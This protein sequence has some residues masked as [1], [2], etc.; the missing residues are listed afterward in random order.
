MKKG[1]EHLIATPALKQWAKL[2]SEHSGHLLLFRVGDFYECFF[3]DAEE[4]SSLLNIALTRRTVAQGSIPMAGVPHHASSQYISKLKSLGK[5]VAL[6][7]QL[8]SPE[9]ARAA[10]RRV[11]KRAVTRIITPGTCVDDEYLA[12]DESAL[13]VAVAQKKQKKTLEV[14]WSDV[15]AGNG[16]WK[17]L[18]SVEEVLSLLSA[19]SPH[20]ILVVGEGA[21]KSWA[22]PLCS[23]QLCRTVEISSSSDDDGAREAIERYLRASLMSNN[24]HRERGQK[25]WSS[26]EEDDGKSTMALLHADGGT[27]SALEL[28]HSSGTTPQ[29]MPWATSTSASASSGIGSLLNVFTSCGHRYSAAALRLL[30]QRINNPLHPSEHEEILSRLKAVHYLMTEPTLLRVLHRI[31]T[32]SPMYGDAE[33]ALQRI[34][35]A[36]QRTPL[37]LAR[38]LRS[39][40]LALQMCALL[41]KE[42]S[43]YDASPQRWRSVNV[44]DQLQRVCESTLAMVGLDDLNVTDVLGIVPGADALLDSL[45]DPKSFE[46]ELQALQNK[47]SET[48]GGIPVK[49]SH[50]RTPEEVYFSVTDKHSQ[51]VS[52]HARTNMSFKYVGQ[53]ASTTRWTT[54][55]LERFGK[56]F[57]TAERDAMKRSRMLL[58]GCR[59]SL[60]QHVVEAKEALR[61]LYDL[62]L[63]CGVATTALNVGL[64]IPRVIVD[65]SGAT[66]KLQSF[67][68]PVVRHL[69]G[70]VTSNDL[71]LASGTSRVA[72]V[73]GANMGGKST[74]LRSVALASWC[75]QAGLPSA[76]SNDSVLSLFDA[77]FVRCGSADDVARDRS[78]FLTEM[79]GLS[80]LLSVSSSVSNAVLCCLDELGRSTAPDDG[81]AIC[82]AVARDLAA[83]DK[84]LTLISTHYS[85]LPELWKKGLLPQTSL[86]HLQVIESK[87]G[88]HLFTHKLL[89]GPSTESHAFHVAS[90]A[91]VPERILDD[92]RMLRRK[93][94]D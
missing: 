46:E 32:K 63:S 78:S 35:L 47:I 64:N 55:D 69:R 17:E 85:A 5:T 73:T 4:L 71:S 81:A 50:G 41:W 26:F 20:E 25:K 6:A 62:D 93:M 18:Q 80:K 57:A 3:E 28:T 76:V 77:I 92:A 36:I 66:L 75:T 38:D 87:D 84:T 30:R 79:S 49:V 90:L 34:N 94:K 22:A 7:D 33:R 9:E 27:R 29:R 51:A 72:V 42:L 61:C 11:V 65:P 43:M 60:M 40:S 31:L 56:R 54:D 67:F 19:L 48:L 52:E 83:R 91:G 39:V 16:G 37:H 70:Q 10:G 24:D 12:Q 53:R 21:T 58:E 86:F 14:A 8:E 82:A 23:Q 68:H 88:T 45:R 13:L 1:L 89:E 74:A 59:E 2:K 44:S 15:A